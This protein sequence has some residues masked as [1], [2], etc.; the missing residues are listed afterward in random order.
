MSAMMHTD[1]APGT[2]P[3]A[4]GKLR[5]VRDPA[6]VR[7][8]IPT[9]VRKT[10]SQRGEGYLVAE[11]P[12]GRGENHGVEALE[13][14]LV[15]TSPRAWGKRWSSNV[16]CRCRGNIPTGVGKTMRCPRSKKHWPEHPHGRGENMRRLAKYAVWSGTSPR[17]WGKRR[18]QH[19]RAPRIRNI[20][21]GVGKTGMDRHFT[22]FASEHPHGRGENP[23]VQ[24]V[25]RDVNGTSPRAWG[26]RMPPATDLDPA[27]N[28]PTGVGK[29]RL[30]S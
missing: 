15:G 29:T 19:R 11:H 24:H 2:S 23:E 18:N 20:P 5:R 26:K 7:R 6:C 25:V 13:Q 3:R 12:H 14:P 16:R 27:R 9:G 10:V 30:A 4:W 17:A 21:T 8:N 22:T 28:I 1:L